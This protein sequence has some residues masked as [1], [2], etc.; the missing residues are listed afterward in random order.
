MCDVFLGACFLESNVLNDMKGRTKPIKCVQQCIMY[1]VFES[2][3]KRFWQLTSTIR[4]LFRQLLVN[5]WQTDSYRDFAFYIF[6]W[7]IPLGSERKVKIEM[8]IIGT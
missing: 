2:I 8:Y 5:D 4:I 3:F 1:I 7:F 6:F